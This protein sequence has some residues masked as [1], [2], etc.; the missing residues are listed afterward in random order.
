MFCEKTKDLEDAFMT[1]LRTT[2]S[3]KIKEGKLILLDKSKELATFVKVDDPTVAL[4][5]EAGHDVAFV[6][7][8]RQ[9]IVGIIRWKGNARHLHVLS[10]ADS[11]ILFRFILQND[12]RRNMRGRNFPVEPGHEHTGDRPEQVAL[13]THPR[14]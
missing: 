6:G 7:A 10:V 13:P 1:A 5:R 8:H 3:Y 14:L 12:G 11:R 2:N 4:S 9:R